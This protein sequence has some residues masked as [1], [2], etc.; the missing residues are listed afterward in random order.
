MGN[1]FWKGQTW[2]QSKVFWNKDLMF[3]QFWWI[4]N[5]KFNLDFNCD[6][7]QCFSSQ[8]STSFT[9][10][11]QPKGWNWQMLNKITLEYHENE[12]TIKSML[13]ILFNFDLNSDISQHLTSQLSVTSPKISSSFALNC[14]PLNLKLVI[15]L[16][17]S[18]IN[19]IS[20][21]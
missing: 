4:K 12:L 14:K 8:L 17:K 5:Y 1:I 6:E 20:N 2:V 15:L 16:N 10:G 9:L 21:I 3:I 7:S 11:R 19:L 13:N 18:N